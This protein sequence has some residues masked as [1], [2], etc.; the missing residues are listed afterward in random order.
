M[1]NFSK[2]IE[3]IKQ[4]E[5]ETVNKEIKPSTDAKQKKRAYLKENTLLE[6]RHDDLIKQSYQ[7]MEKKLET[8]EDNDM[9]GEV[10]NILYVSKRNWER[11]RNDSIFK[12]FPNKWKYFIAD[13][14]RQS[15]L[16]SVAKETND[17]KIKKKI[18]F[19]MVD[20]SFTTIKNIMNELNH[21]M[22][23]DYP[24]IQEYDPNKNPNN[25]L[26]E[27]HYLEREWKDA[28]KSWVPATGSETVIIDLGKYKWFDLGKGACRDEG[29]AM[30][31]CGNVP[32]VSTG[33][34]IYSLRQ[35]KDIQG[36]EYHRPSLTFIA[37]DGVLGEMKGRSNNKPN[38]K[39]HPYIMELLKSQYI[40][41]IKGG[42]YMPEN[43][44]HPNDLTPEQREELIEIK[45]EE[46]LDTSGM[47]LLVKLQERFDNGEDVV[48]N[49]EKVVRDMYDNQEDDADEMSTIYYQVFPEW[50]DDRFY[51]MSADLIEY[52]INEL[53]DYIAG[54]S[55]ISDNTIAEMDIDVDFNEIVDTLDFKQREGLIDYFAAKHSEEIEF[56]SD[57]PDESIESKAET[58]LDTLIK[59]GV[60]DQFTDIFF[61]EFYDNIK[62]QI[63]ETIKEQISEY[64]YEIMDDLNLDTD[65]SIN[66]IDGI[67]SFVEF[68]FMY[69]K[70]N[71]VVEFINRLKGYVIREVD[72]DVDEIE[73]DG[74]DPDMS[75]INE[76]LK[77]IGIGK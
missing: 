69:I 27:L 40:K 18:K 41:G 31:H 57:E 30:G 60:S 15:L 29:E 46:F 35:V 49:I 54:R 5:K 38:K 22:G 1:S 48:D 58:F 77:N 33:D 62:Y 50:R 61:D 73:I 12:S 59:H 26:N 3:L 24:P 45:G 56:Y 13:V 42:G 47:A 55:T 52:S 28:S 11:I 20:G 2:M 76:R 8:I 67:L 75:K 16:F 21:Y 37:N 17:P 9:K 53:I 44:F 14:V 36:K 43:N 4:A 39:Y 19:D 34:V 68:P 7:A 64:F 51:V 71:N 10:G 65:E 63:L 66:T 32:S 6:G 70:N 25:A 23:I 72:F 74:Y